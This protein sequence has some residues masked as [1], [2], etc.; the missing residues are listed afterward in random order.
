[1]GNVLIFAEQR[2]G[3]FRTAAF[4]AVRKGKEIA[5]ALGGSA[6]AVAIGQGVAGIAPALAHYGADR[7]IVAEAPA[8][9]LFSIEGYAGVLAAVAGK[10]AP[11]AIVVPA[12][13]MGKDVGAGVA[14]RLGVPAVTDCVGVE[15][16]DGALECTRPVYAGKTLLTLRLS[17]KPNVVSLRPKTFAAGEPDASKNVEIE[18]YD[19]EIPAVRAKTVAV[20]GKGDGKIDLTEADFIVSG[21][22]GMKS[23]ENFNVLELLAEKL[24]GVVGASRAAVDSGWRDHTDQV[25]Q[26]GKVVSPTLY[27]ACGISGAIQ[28]LAG[29][30][31]SKFIVAINKDPEAGIFEVADYGIVG[32]LFDIVPSL[33][34]EIGKIAD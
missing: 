15:V 26:T 19:G 31:T 21:G 18:K 29:M 7:I 17:C 27:I 2:G 5:S 30:S 22:R 16:K 34:E 13:I 33:T 3:K 20:E 12:T 10:E 25:G 1:M 8:L 14:A 6:V 11:A 4:E 9:E 24:G 23:A 28:H 32:D